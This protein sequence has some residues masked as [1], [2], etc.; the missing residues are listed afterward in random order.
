MSPPAAAHPGF[1]DIRADDWIHRR[2][3]RAARPYARL[4]RLDR[5]IGW[6]LLLLPGWWSLGLAS[7]SW[8]HIG[9]YLLFW[10][11][12]VVM[13]GA[14]CTLNDIADRNFDAAVERTRTRPIP[15][16]EVSVFQAV[17]YLAVQLLIG[18]IVLFSLNRQ[19]IVLGF[20]VLILI[21]TYPFM[22]R[23]TFWPQLFL[24]LNFNWGALIA[25][26]AV[27]GRLETPAIVL[28]AAG[29]AWTLG[30]DTIYAH[31]DKEDDI[32]IG[33]K[34]TALRLGA[35]SRQWV[36][37]FYAVTWTGVLTAF[38]LAHAAFWAY[39]AL[40][41]LAMHFLWQVAGWNMDDQADCLRRFKSNR[42]AG[43]IIAAGCLA[44]HL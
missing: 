23:I 24:G 43:L 36:A 42:T 7:P 30:Y 6:W 9:L 39:L 15:A 27:M 25:W 2:L 40:P 18:A 14:G 28:Y 38:I 32:K 22:K 16:G 12:A 35:S 1:S 41:F 29:I 20:G 17:A 31:Q 34:S 10:I 5:P 4:S 11:G 26:T 44:A 19:A 21:A 37:G 33:V 8:H 13:R 3:P